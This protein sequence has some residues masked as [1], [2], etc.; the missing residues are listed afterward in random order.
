MQQW[1][2][3][4]GVF[5]QQQR[6]MCF[7]VQERHRTRVLPHNL[8]SW[9]LQI[10]EQMAVISGNVISITALGSWTDP[11][12]D[13]VH[14]DCRTINSPGLVFVDQWFVF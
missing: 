11:A 14:V 12:I 3:I 10:S 1:S 4:W 2:R 9:L 8:A 6:K 13:M 5:K 7:L